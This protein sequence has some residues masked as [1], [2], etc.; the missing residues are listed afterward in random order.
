MA[1]II[2]RDGK[3]KPW[4]AQVHRKGHRI[5]SRSFAQ[6]KDAQ[7]WA[8]EQ[9]RTIDLTGLPL[10]IEELKNTT[11]GDLVDRYLEKV[12]P[13]KASRENEPVIQ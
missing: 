1:S 13:R 12:T 5:F 2:F 3:S 10:T 4:L 6:K 11:V 7:R 8:A 9:E